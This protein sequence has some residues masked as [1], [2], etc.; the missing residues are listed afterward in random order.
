MVNVHLQLR[1]ECS[2]TLFVGCGEHSTAFGTGV[3]LKERRDLERCTRGLQSQA[4]ELLN[5]G[6]CCKWEETNFERL[7]LSGGFYLYGG[8]FSNFYNGS[9]AMQVGL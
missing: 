5:K 4:V 3:N 2:E 6:N 9:K 8:L 7:R 1:E